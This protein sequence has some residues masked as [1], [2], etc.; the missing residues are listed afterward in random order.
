VEQASP[1]IDGC[2]LYL[3]DS[4]GVYSNSSTATITNTLLRENGSHGA[5]AAG[6]S[7]PNL[8]N[9]YISENGEFGV[10]N[11][12]ATDLLARNNWWGHPSGPQHPTTNPEG[13]GD[14]VSDC[15][16]FEPYRISFAEVPQELQAVLLNGEAVNG[17]FPQGVNGFYYAVDVPAGQNLSLSIDDAND[18]GV[19]QVY[20][21]R[22]GYPTPSN[23]QLR[24][25]T[26]GADQRLFV[27]AAGPGRWYALVYQ[28]TPEESSDFTIRADMADVALHGV[29]PERHANTVPITMTITGAGFVGDTKVD[30]VA[31]VQIIQATSVEVDSFTHLTA[32]FPPN[33]PPGI[34]DVRVTVPGKTP[35]W[36]RHAFEA[37]EGGRPKLVTDLIIPAAVGYHQLAT[38]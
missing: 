31:G 19:T 36:R 1:Y 32:A 30:L 2:D 22:S 23:Y 16:L 20:L 29:S 15:V 10:R 34:F 8:A 37:L 28:F 35:A 6:S 26:K 7:V 14:L 33:I 18:E 3:N 24:Q 5:W 27:P 9:C 11:Q 25:E 13:E 21:S 4:S 38:L 17:T 12:A